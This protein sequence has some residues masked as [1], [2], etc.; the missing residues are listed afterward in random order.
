MSGLWNP[1]FWS[2]L[3][4]PALALLVVVL[5]VVAQLR[6]WIVLGPT[7]RAVVARMDDRAANDA[8]T[9]AFLLREKDPSPA[10]E[11]IPIVTSLRDAATIAA[12]GDG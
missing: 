8:R 4:A 2:S 1:E 11:L 3:G 9:I 6:G 10:E 5:F 12:A 7:H